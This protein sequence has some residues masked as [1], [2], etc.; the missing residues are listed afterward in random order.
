MK[1][2]TSPLSRN[3][4]GRPKDAAKRTSIIEAAASLFMSEGYTETSMEAVATKAGVSK[5]TIYS[6]FADKNELFKEVIRRRC[7]SQAM[8][9]SYLAMASEPVK[10]ALLAIAS[11]FTRLIYNPDSLRLHRIM[12]AEAQRH[13]EVVQ[14]FYDIGP[15]RVR[16]AFGELLTQWV[17]QKKLSIPDIATATEQFFSLVKGELM[18]KSLLG[19]GPQPSKAELDKHI[20]AAI[21]MFL[22]T[23]QPKTTSTR[24][25]S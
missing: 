3:P 6:H 18:S 14:I 15:K 5:L 17:K 12:Q 22:S 21:T 8:P 7:D 20:Q 1:P 19:I 16:A 2:T 13:P 11:K 23:Y 4:Q 10:P 24:L 25:P 9:E